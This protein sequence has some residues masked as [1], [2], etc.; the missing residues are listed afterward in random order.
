MCAHVAAQLLNF[1]AELVVVG[2]QFLHSFHER[3]NDLGITDR[4]RILDSLFLS[5]AIG[6]GRRNSLLTDNFRKNLFHLLRDETS[7]SPCFV[8]MSLSFQ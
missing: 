3:D 8:S 2:F 1:M 5:V 7:L 6:D 4:F